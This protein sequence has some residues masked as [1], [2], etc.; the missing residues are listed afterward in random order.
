M[1]DL[2]GMKYTLLIPLGKQLL[3][4]RTLEFIEPEGDLI[5]L[6]DRQ[7]EESCRVDSSESLLYP[8]GF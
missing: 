4:E 2:G 3:M 1:G 7:K 5:K 8:G 6:N